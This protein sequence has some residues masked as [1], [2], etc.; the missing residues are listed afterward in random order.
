MNAMLSNTTGNDNT[1]VGEFS[2]E[3]NV[4]GIDNA[5]FG[6]NALVN[7]YAGSY[8]TAV[9]FNAL[10]GLTPLGYSGQGNTALGY[11]AG[12]LSNFSGTNTLFLGY[13]AVPGNAN[14][15]DATA[16][17]ANAVVS[18]SYTMQLGGSGADAV[19]VKTSSMTVN[20]FTYTQNTTGGGSAALGANSPAS[21]NTAPYTW[22]KMKSSDGSTVYVPAWK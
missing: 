17:G 16:I 19:M 15:T 4:S 22:F 1:A 7:N 5:A 13:N 14:L 18:S 20:D 6:S 2:L 21:T 10:W 9:G 11:W 3:S 12:G 8:N